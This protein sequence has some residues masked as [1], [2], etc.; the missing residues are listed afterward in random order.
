MTVFFRSALLGAALA[1]LSSTSL[2]VDFGRTAGNFGVTPSGAAT[3]T[4][5]IWTPPGPNG[6]QPSIALS[7]SSQNGNGL[8]GVGWNLAAVSSIE[9][10]QLTTGQ[11]GADGAVTLTSLD[12]FCIGGSRLRVLNGSN[13]GDLG[14]IYATELADFSGLLPLERPAWGRT[15]SSSRR[16]ADSNTSTGIRRTPR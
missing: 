1:L 8:A 9:R 6:V 12:R 13:Y 4:I 10:C 11:D 16:R 5:P 15:I 2:A 3:Y 7:Y 14:A